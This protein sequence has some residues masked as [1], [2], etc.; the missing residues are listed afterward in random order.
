[1]ATRMGANK[2]CHG[3]GGRR[4]AGWGLAGGGRPARCELVWQYVWK[5]VI[6]ALI[7]HI[8]ALIPAA[9]SLGSIPHQ[10]WGSPGQNSQNRSVSPR[11][12]QLRSLTVLRPHSLHYG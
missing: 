10:L 5:G 6:L 4:L 1:M 3:V 2:C 8:P 7:L 11:A 9:S 12:E